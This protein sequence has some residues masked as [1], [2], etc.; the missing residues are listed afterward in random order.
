MNKF[1]QLLP[2]KQSEQ[3]LLYVNN[4]D[5]WWSSTL[6]YAIHC[7]N[8][9]MFFSFLLKIK[10]LSTYTNTKC[11]VV[12]DSTFHSVRIGI[13]MKRSTAWS[14]GR[15]VSFALFGIRCAFNQPKSHIWRIFSQK[16]KQNSRRQVYKSK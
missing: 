8:F 12:C 7:V 9:C 4:K 15:S 13:S 2:Q 11:G 10:C 1:S 5:A 3:N 14:Y 16:K 6:L